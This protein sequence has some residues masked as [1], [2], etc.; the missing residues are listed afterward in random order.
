[1]VDENFV[2]SRIG[3]ALVSAQRVEFV[4]G[5]ILDH[6][7]EFDKSVYGVTTDEFLSKSAKPGKA[8]K[9]LGQIFVMLNLNPKLVIEDDLNAYRDM[10][11]TFVHGFWRKFLDKK[12]EE[13][14]KMA[15]EFCYEFGRF[16]ERMESFFKGFLYFLSLRHEKD[17]DS[18]DAEIREWDEDF[19][20]FIT[21]LQAKNIQ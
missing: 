5:Q 17:R 8:T 7:V 3:M 20:F 16:S 15:V 4:A 19:G 10:R 21:T 13:Q 1:M 18:L 6:L 9:T 12:T 2:Y 14:T 11:N